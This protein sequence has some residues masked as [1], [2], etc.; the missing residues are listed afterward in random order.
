MRFLFHFHIW[1]TLNE[2]SWLEVFLET[3]RRM[4]F[5]PFSHLAVRPAFLSPLLGMC[6]FLSTPKYYEEP[7]QGVGFCN[8]E[9]EPSADSSFCKKNPQTEWLVSRIDRMLACGMWA[10]FL[11]PLVTYLLY[12]YDPSLNHRTAQLRDLS[13]LSY[14]FN[15]IQVLFIEQNVKDDSQLAQKQVN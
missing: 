3:L 15:S 5:P 7:Q 12:L 14:Y 8:V 6:S 2:V 13:Q 11:L 9:P 1:T 10:I 4:F